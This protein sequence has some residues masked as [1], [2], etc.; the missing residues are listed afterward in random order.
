MRASGS[1]PSSF[2]AGLGGDQRAGGAV[3]EGRGVA[4]GD[5]AA[6]AEG[7]AQLRHLLQRGVGARAL[8]GLDGDRLAPLRRLD[9]DDLLGEEPG[10]G[11]GDGALVAAQAEGVLVLAADPVA[12]GDVLAGLAHR[13]RS[14]RRARPC[15]G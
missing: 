8:V 12:L 15:A 4:G 5:G 10:L 1:A 2:G 3:V 14:R 6:L 13:L 9:R 11:G 7:R